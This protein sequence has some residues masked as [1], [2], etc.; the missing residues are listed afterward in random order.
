MVSI[1][2]LDPAQE[3]SIGGI[4]V[5]DEFLFP[6]ARGLLDG[7]RSI[8]NEVY[9]ADTGRRSDYYWEYLI[10]SFNS[11]SGEHVKWL[12]RLRGRVLDDNGSIED[13]T[14]HAGNPCFEL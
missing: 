7:D 11:G 2:R 8:I 10:T 9:R 6:L 14:T 13:T 3:P 4:S 12:R 1:Y 5:P